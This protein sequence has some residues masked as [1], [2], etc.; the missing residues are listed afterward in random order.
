LDH[1]FEEGRVSIRTINSAGLKLVEEFEQLRLTAYRPTA[2]DPWTIGW[3]HTSGVRAGQQCTPTQAALWLHQ[4][5]SWAEQ[6][7]ER[8]VH[9]ALSDDQYS[10]LVCFTFNAGGGNLLNLVARSKLNYGYYYAVPEHL[11]QYDH[12]ESGAV[13]DGLVRRRKAEVELWNGGAG[14]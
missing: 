8:A 9:V 10:A 5:L 1:L 6:D 12:G 7:V 2:S 11:L 3:G 4:D 13:L 14:I